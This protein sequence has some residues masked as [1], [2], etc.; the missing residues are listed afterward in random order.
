MNDID[1]MGCPRYQALRDKVVKESLD[2]SSFKKA[3]INELNP[4]IERITKLSMNDTY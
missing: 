3:I 1:G 2:Y 4:Y